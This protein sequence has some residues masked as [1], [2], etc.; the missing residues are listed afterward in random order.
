MPEH[1]GFDLSQINGRSM[2]QLRVR[3]GTA[4]AAC[5]ALQ[6]PQQPLR[7]WGEDPA[8]YWLG[9]DHWLLTSDT[10]PAKDIIRQIDITL[11]GQLYA[12]TDMSSSNVCFALRGPAARRVLAMGCGIDVHRSAFTTGHC[13]RT[14]FA[15]VLLFIVVVEDD[16]FNLY[17]DRS[18]ARYLRNWLV[19]AGE[20]PITRD[21]KYRAAE[22]SNE[23]DSTINGKSNQT[24]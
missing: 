23:H 10:K 5:K 22:V 24:G 1:P 7:W 4:D 13:T 3:P 11:A 8:A 14:H 12:A 15:N 21:L 6:L 2:V 17:V 20:D 19:N 18:L 16:N 9:P